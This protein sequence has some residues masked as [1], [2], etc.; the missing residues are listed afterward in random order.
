MNTTAF[1]IYKANIN[2]FYIARI[3]DCDD[4][5]E[6][7]AQYASHVITQEVIDEKDQYCD[8]DGALT[9]NDKAAVEYIESVMSQHLVGYS[10]TIMVD[11][12]STF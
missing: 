4:Q 1:A 2:G 10:F 3:D 12:F 11:W 6:L 7:E 5:G 8:A 9:I